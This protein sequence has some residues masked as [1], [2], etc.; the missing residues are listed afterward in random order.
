MR[1]RIHRL[2]LDLDSPRELDILK[3]YFNTKTVCKQPVFSKRTGH[4]VHFKTYIDTT[5]QQNLTLRTLL[6]DDVGRIRFDEER[7]HYETLHDWVDTT[8]TVKK[9]QGKKLTKE[10]PFEV[11]ALPFCSQLPARKFLNH[12]K[13]N[14]LR[15]LHV[16]S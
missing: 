4:G 8:F 13:R 12:H 1:L 11:L 9:K 16:R 7:S 14:I 5:I 2:A 3:S 15:K 6:G 10:E